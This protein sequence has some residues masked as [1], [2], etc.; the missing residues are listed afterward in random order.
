MLLA[1]GQFLWNDVDLVEV[2]AGLVVLQAGGSDF[3]L[4]DEDVEVA[5]VALVTPIVKHEAVGAHR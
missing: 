4:V 2:V 5:E 3:G 1:G